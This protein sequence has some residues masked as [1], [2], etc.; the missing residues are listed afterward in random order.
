[1]QIPTE[2]EN[3]GCLASAVFWVL[4]KFNQGGLSKLKCMLLLGKI[5]C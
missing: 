5:I 2:S 1:M 4:P 3:Y